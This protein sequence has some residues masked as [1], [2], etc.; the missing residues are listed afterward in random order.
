MTNENFYQEGAKKLEKRDSTIISVDGQNRK[1]SKL[2]HDFSQE[3][4]HELIDN[5]AREAIEVQFL[6]KEQLEEFQD[7][8]WLVKVDVLADFNSYFSQN[9][10][11]LLREKFTPEKRMQQKMERIYHLEKIHHSHEVPQLK[12]DAIKSLIGFIPT[13]NDNTTN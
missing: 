13:E 1:T 12:T 10:P 8:I 11:H 7:E 6:R 5:K 3:D 2:P 9:N 4:L